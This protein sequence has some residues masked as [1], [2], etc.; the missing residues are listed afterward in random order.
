M[1]SEYK[2]SICGEIH[3][4]YPALAYPYPDSYYWLTEGEKNNYP[5]YLDSNF[6]KIEYPDEICR[7]IRVVLKQKII[8]SDLTLDY[9]LW[10]SLSEKSYEDYF[11]NF[12]NKNHETVYFG[13]LDNNIPNYTFD[14]SIPTDV[15]TKVGSERPEIFPH[16]D[17]EHLFVKDYYEGITVEEAE[18]RVHD[19]LS[20]ISK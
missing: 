10:V 7:F 13:W 15:K 5:I 17:C 2:C 18:K 19:M 12:N 1:T 8:N 14:K 4:D 20:Y 6:C 3:A 16:S 9:G 11:L